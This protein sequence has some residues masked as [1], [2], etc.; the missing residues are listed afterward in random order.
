MIKHVARLLVSILFSA[1]PA[2]NIALA[3]DAQHPPV[4][5]WSNQPG[6]GQIVMDYDFT[7]H[8]ELFQ[9]FC[10]PGGATCLYTSIDPGFLAE[11]QDTTD[12]QSY[13]LA[14]GTSVSIEIT[15]IDPGL[16][17]SVNGNRLAAAGARAKLGTMPT[18]HVHPSWQLLTSEP[19]GQ[20]IHL[21]YRLIADNGYG[22]SEVVTHTIVS[23]EPE[24]TPTPTPEVPACAGDCDASGDVTVDEIQKA[25]SA[26]LGQQAPCDAVD[27]DGSGTVTVDE[28]IT[29]VTNALEGCGIEPTPTPAPVT[30]AEVQAEVFD[31]TCAIPTCHG[32]VDRVG[33]LDL[34]EGHA[35]E[36]IVRVAPSNFAA[37]QAGML[38]ID[39]G[40]LETSFIW[41]KVGDPSPQYGGRMPI[42][43]DPLS[44]SQR[45]LLRDWILRGAPAE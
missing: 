24:P 44:D 28:I 25:V 32:A 29:A 12:D 7:R 4:Y 39:P 18:L 2:P 37:Q 20:E 16:T 23:V 21:S 3:H 6:G 31:V 41:I 15:A 5:L 43:R 33:G 11:P 17:L 27:T 42:D 19:P 34:S 10:T 22:A 40:Q 38:R 30:L 1:I 45:S 26:A 36:S 13:P 8:V 14:N 35:Y 9:T